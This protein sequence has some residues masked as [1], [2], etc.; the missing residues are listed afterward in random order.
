MSAPGEPDFAAEHTRPT[1][2]DEPATDPPDESVPAGRGGDGGMDVR[3]RS[4]AH[5]WWRRLLRTLHLG[6]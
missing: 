2:S 1:Y 3:G 6:D 5:G 4:G